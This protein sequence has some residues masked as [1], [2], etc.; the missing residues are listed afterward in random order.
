MALTYAIVKTYGT[1]LASVLTIKRACE[2]AMKGLACE[3]AKVNDMRVDIEIG[4]N[5][6][7]ST[8]TLA[9]R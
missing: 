3:A 1:P 6:T 5:R 7:S 4:A 9:Q 8:T 2:A